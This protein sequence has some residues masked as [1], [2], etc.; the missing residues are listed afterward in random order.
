[1]HER[2]ADAKGRCRVDHQRKTR[3]INTLIQLFPL[4]MASVV[5]TN[6]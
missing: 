2:V 3:R 4:Q 1:M 6:V 5:N